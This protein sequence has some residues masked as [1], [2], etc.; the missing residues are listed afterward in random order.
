[1]SIIEARRERQEIFYKNLA[2]VNGSHLYIVPLVEQI[3]LM[4]I[5]ETIKMNPISE[6]EGFLLEANFGFSQ[7]PEGLKK[8]L[9]EF[10]RFGNEEGALLIKGLPQDPDLP[11]TPLNG[12][13]PTDK[14]TYFS[15]FW[16]ALFSTA[17]GQPYGFIQEKD[18]ELYQ[19]ISPTKDNQDTQTSESSSVFLQ[20]HTETSFHPFLPDFVLL[21]CLRA[22]HEKI[23]RTPVASVRKFISSIP[24]V[25][26]DVLREPLFA[27]TVDPSFGGKIGEQGMTMSLMYGEN[28]DPFFRYDA[29][30]TMP[31]NQQANES[32]MV[33]NE[34]IENTSGYV[35]LEPGD[36][37]ILDNNRSL[38]ARSEFKARYDGYDRWLQRFLITRNLDKSVEQRQGRIISTKF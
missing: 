12:R 28:Y 31:L 23:A 4:R 16:L 34:A 29:A 7:L 19:T 25:H 21:Y 30:Q 26:Q 2:D 9:E 24:L 10:K 36:L 6:F 13:Y 35:K 17:L 27:I 8:R 14:S 18:G 37:I 1:M 32:L 5:V 33:L 3:G 38:H 22:D 11:A 20:F 15:E